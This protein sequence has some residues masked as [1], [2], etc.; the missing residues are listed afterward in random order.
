MGH[1]KLNLIGKTFNRLKVLELKES[2]LYGKTFKRMW[3]CV[4]ECGKEL[5]L[6]TGTLTTGN[7][8]SCGCLHNELSSENSIKSRYKIAKPDA[9]FT[10]IMNSY[11]RNA[12]SRGVDFLLDF[13]NFKKIIQSNCFYCGVEPSNLYF[14]NYYDVKYNGI[15]RVDNKQG[16]NLNN[17]VPCCKICNIAK[18]NNSTEIFNNWINRLLNKKIKEAINNNNGNIIDAVNSIIND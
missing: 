17:V 15:D 8:K 10:S 7:T 2:R 3:L 1:K 11:K 12:I 14:K 18:N 4:C 6:N 9:G 5:I 13:D 16:Y